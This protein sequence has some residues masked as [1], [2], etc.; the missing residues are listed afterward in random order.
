MNTS[1]P[2]A[3][4]LQGALADGFADRLVDRDGVEPFG[5]GFALV[6]QEVNQTQSLT[7]GTQLRRPRSCVPYLRCHVTTR[8]SGSL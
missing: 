2:F 7:L 6:T 8:S 5:P 4:E 3:S 1:S